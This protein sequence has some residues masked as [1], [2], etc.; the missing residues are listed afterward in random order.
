MEQTLYQSVH[1]N[2]DMKLLSAYGSKGKFFHMKEFTNSLEKFGVQCEIVECT[3]YS[4]MI[5]K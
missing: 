3:H 4:K 1:H 2:S 5:P